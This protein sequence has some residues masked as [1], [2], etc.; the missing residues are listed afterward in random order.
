[1]IYRKKLIRFIK[2]RI[3]QPGERSVNHQGSLEVYSLK[4]TSLG[5]AKA[6]ERLIVDSVD[7]LNENHEVVPVF[8]NLLFQSVEMTLK[9]LATESELVTIKDLRNNKNFGNGHDIPKLAKFIERELDGQSVVDLL[10]P[11]QGFADSNIILNEMISGD[12]FARSRSSYQRRNITYSQFEKGELQVVDGLND[13]VK[14]VKKAAENIDN[15]L[16]EI[17]L[18]RQSKLNI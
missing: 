10:L 12:R 2:R 14:A 15:G 18:L 6:A 4:E 17:S 16:L 1:M 11:R 9:S 8:V 5:H 13:W 3:G 7:F